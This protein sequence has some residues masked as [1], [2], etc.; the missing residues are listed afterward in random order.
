M[1]VFVTFATISLLF[2]IGAVIVMFP[3]TGECYATSIRGT[4][5]A[6]NVLLLRFGGAIAPLIAV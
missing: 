3:Y 1:Y 4:G 5:V 6:T 2:G